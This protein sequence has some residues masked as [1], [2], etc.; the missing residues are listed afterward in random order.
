MASYEL[1]EKTV[2]PLF[3]V[4]IEADMND[5]DYLTNINQYS[6][7]RFHD[8]L[9]DELIELNKIVGKSDALYGF[10]D[11]YANVPFDTQ[12]GESCHTLAS[13]DI[14]YIDEQGK[15]W[16]VAL[17]DTSTLTKFEEE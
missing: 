9:I 16:D 1:V 12:S 5:G 14:E 15:I 11:Q 7:D 6:K 17:K 3:R 13:L 2:K 10:N 4:T 8:K